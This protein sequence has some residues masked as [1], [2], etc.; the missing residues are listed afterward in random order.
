MDIM[1]VDLNLLRVFHAIAEENSLTLAGNRLGLSQPAVSYAL[2]RLRAMFNDPLFVRSGNTMQPTSAAL[3]L[4]EPIRRAMSS[5]QE[6][7]RYGERFDPGRSTRTF[8]ITMSDIGEMVFL[9]PLCEKLRD[10]APNIRL[11]VSQLPLVQIEEALRSGRLD[12]AI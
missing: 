1:K 5:I 3:E 11:E 8:H 12:L 7:L 10:V 6:A 2:G 9:P 4:R